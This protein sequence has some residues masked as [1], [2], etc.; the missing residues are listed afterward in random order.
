[1]KK[2]LIAIGFCAALMSTNLFAGVFF[3][4][5]GDLQND[6]RIDIVWR[7]QSGNCP[8]KYPVESVDCNYEY[9]NIGGL[10]VNHLVDVSSRRWFTTENTFEFT[11][12]LSA[13]SKNKGYA[14]NEASCKNLQNVLQTNSTVTINKTGCIVS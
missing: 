11:I 10:V 2:Q 6:D 3:L 12:S 5:Q 8:T 7:K 1:M 4:K 9:Q 14:F 13:A